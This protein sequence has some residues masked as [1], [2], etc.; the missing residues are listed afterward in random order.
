MCG[1]CSGLKEGWDF[2]QSEPR[3]LRKGYGIRWSG[4]RVKFRSK[5]GEKGQDSVR[6]PGNSGPECVKR[7][8]HTRTDLRPHKGILR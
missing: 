1:V 5:K 4:R 8:D 7:G 3:E 2:G 6:P